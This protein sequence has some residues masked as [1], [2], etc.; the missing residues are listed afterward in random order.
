MRDG[1]ANRL[2]NGADFRAELCG[3][4]KLKDKKFLYYLAPTIDVRI[5]LCIE[6]C[7]NSTVI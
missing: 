5:T 4:D 2:I 7:P 3:T 1:D 6:K